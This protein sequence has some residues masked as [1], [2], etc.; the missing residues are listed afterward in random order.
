MPPTSPVATRTRRSTDAARAWSVEAPAFLAVLGAPGPTRPLI[1]TEAGGAYG[2]ATLTVTVNGS[3]PR[4]IFV[5]ARV[6]CSHVVGWR[7]RPSDHTPRCVYSTFRTGRRPL[8]RRD[9]PLWTALLDVL[10]A[11]HLTRWATDVPL[12]AEDLARPR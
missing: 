12:P 10:R 8:A 6:L 1:V 3:P 2:P 5:L 11:C 7:L 4:A 9:V